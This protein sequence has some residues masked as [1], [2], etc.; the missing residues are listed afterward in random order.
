MTHSNTIAARTNSNRSAAV[1]EFRAQ[2][3]AQEAER[4]QRRR[5]AADS[6]VYQR[7]DAIKRLAAAKSAQLPKLYKAQAAVNRDASLTDQQKKEQRSELDHQLNLRI[8]VA[9]AVIDNFVHAKPNRAASI[10]RSTAARLLTEGQFPVSLAAK[11]S[12]DEGK[13]LS[14]SPLAEGLRLGVKLLIEA[15]RAMNESA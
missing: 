14:D 3:A 15:G 12:D 2:K 1:R 5:V 10:S 8:R 6:Q 13:L 7:D 4:A 9:E 11:Y